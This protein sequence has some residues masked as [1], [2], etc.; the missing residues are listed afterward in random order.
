MINRYS[1]DAYS[2][3]GGLL[4]ETMSHDPDGEYIR[5]A[6]IPVEALESAI[7]AIALEL[8]TCSKLGDN[9]DDLTEQL[10]QLRELLL[11]VS[12]NNRGN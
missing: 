4:V 9:V 6:D 8:A 1:P 2:D 5:V 12:G 7:N 3:A 11:A 10:Q